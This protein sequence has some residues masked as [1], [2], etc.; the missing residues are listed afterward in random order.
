MSRKPNPWP[1]CAI[2]YA[3]ARDL[4]SE[5]NSVPNRTRWYSSTRYLEIGSCR[6]PITSASTRAPS[7][8]T[9]R[10]VWLQCAKTA[11][12][13]LNRRLW[14]R[15]INRASK[16]WRCASVLPAPQD[17]PQDLAGRRL[18]DLVDHL[19]APDLLVRSDPRRH[20]LHDLF[21]ILRRLQHDERLRHLLTLFVEHSYHR[22]VRDVGMRQQKRLQLGR[23]HLESLVLD[24]LL[25]AV[26]DEVQVAVVDVADVPCVKEAVGIDR[27]LRRLFV[28]Q[29]TTHHLR[30]ANP[31]LSVLIPA[32]LFAGRHVPDLA[33][34]VRRRRSDR[35]WHR[36]VAVRHAVRHRTW[37]GET[38]APA[39]PAPAAR[40]LRL[41]PVRAAGCRAGESAIDR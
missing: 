33:F 11:S 8:S 32:E 36:L 41:S 28:V 30:A 29:V 20:E 12:G 15:L 26:D 13:P 6:T 14:A 10:A 23:R 21:G 22:D 34:R 19:E 17:A 1:T 25:Q 35:A 38:V 31:D 16:W 5:E 40:A 27:A 3:T 18:G 9:N 2:A 7:A 4:P 37:F 24:E 39:D